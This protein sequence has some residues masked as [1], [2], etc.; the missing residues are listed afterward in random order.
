MTEESIE[1]YFGERKYREKQK[2]LTRIE[3]SKE[4]E[5]QMLKE[6]IK[7]YNDNKI[8]LYHDLMDEICETQ[9]NWF[10]YLTFSH[11]GKGLVLDYIKT[12]KKK[13]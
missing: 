13:R 10:N 5:L 11:K 8:D 9:E 12:K 7:Y 2:Q 4:E 1:K 3:F 6:I